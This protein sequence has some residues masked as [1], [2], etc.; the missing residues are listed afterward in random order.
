MSRSVLYFFK[1]EKFFLGL[2]RILLLLFCTTLSYLNLRIKL[3]LTPS[4][5][6]GTLLQNHNSLIQFNYYNNEQS[7]ILQY[8]IPEIIHNIFQINIVNCYLI[9]RLTFISF[10]FYFFYF[11]NKKWITPFQSIIGV[12][13]LALIIPLTYKNHLQESFSF[14]FLS[15]LLALWCIR[16]NKLYAFSF[17]LLIGAL[18]NETILYTP[19]IFL[20]YNSKFR[21]LLF[22]LKKTI[23]ISSPAFIV[24]AIMR[25]VTIDRPH[26]GGAWHLQENMH[27]LDEPFLLFNILWLLPFIFFKRLPY[28]LKC[29]LLSIP[30]FV[31]PHL[32]TGIISETRQM[33][34]L[35]FILIPSSIITWNISFNKNK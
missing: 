2:S 9:Q 11:F 22:V 6:N 23:L 18:N 20:F 15:F 16:E 28:F 8:Y 19:I 1:N 14:L 25:L 26:L 24:A 30:F 7:R 29:A 4:W 27:N 32:I 3:Y 5:Y 21:N 10:A 12:L 34:P 13:I 17:V 35:G 31:I 33:L